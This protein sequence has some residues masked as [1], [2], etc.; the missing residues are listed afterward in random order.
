MSSKL[1]CCCMRGEPRC[2]VARRPRPRCR[3][4]YTA[5]HTKLWLFY[6]TRNPAGHF[7]VWVSNVLVGFGSAE[8]D[9]FKKS[10]LARVWEHTP[11]GPF[12]AQSCAVK[13]ARRWPACPTADST[14]KD[15]RRLAEESLPMRKTSAFH[16]CFEVYIY[17][18]RDE[19]RHNRG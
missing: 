15:L 18:P 19:M 13:C 8:R 6:N 12:R 17:K 14:R 16:T 10:Q 2:K 3:V 9:P 5:G 1:D 4:S 11:A 7:F